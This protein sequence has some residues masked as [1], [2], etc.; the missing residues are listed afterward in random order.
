MD[1]R[2]L[3]EISSAHSRMSGWIVR[4]SLTRRCSG[5]F[6]RLP[7]LFGKLSGAFENAGL[8]DLACLEFH[9]GARG[10]DHGLGWLLGIAAHALL[11]ETG[12]KDAEFTELNAL[13]VC[14]GIGDAVER[15]L[16]HGEDFLLREC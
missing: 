13:A 3:R 2:R 11:G 15:E 14:Q 9:D 1:R 12:G 4:L 6:L 16:D 8:H 10:D 7:I 5:G